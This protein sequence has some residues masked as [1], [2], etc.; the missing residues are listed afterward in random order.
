MVSGLLVVSDLIV[1]I[2]AFFLIIQYLNLIRP[3]LAFAPAFGPRWAGA[4]GYRPNGRA[5]EPVGQ[6]IRAFAK[7]NDQA[8]NKINQGNR[9][10]VSSPEN[11]ID[12]SE[13][14]MSS[15]P[16]QD[17]NQPLAL[18]NQLG[19]TLTASLHL[20]DTVA[21]CRTVLES[22][23]LRDLF[24]FDIAE[25]CLHHKDNGTLMAV[26]RL[27]EETA[28]IR[29]ESS[30][31]SGQ[32]ISGWMMSREQPLHLDDAHTHADPVLQAELQSHPY[33]AYLGVPLKV[34]LKLLGTFVLASTTPGIYTA[35]DMTLL[36]VV[37]GQLSIALDHVRLFDET[38][39][40]VSELSLLFETSQELS[41]T[42]SYSEILQNLSRQMMMAFPA[43][44]C[45]IFDLDEAT[46]VLT[47][48]HRCGS[49]VTRQKRAPLQLT[50][51]FARTLTT[52]TAWEKAFKTRAPFILRTN[53]PSTNV[54][55]TELL[56]HCNCQSLLAVPL[57]S[58]DKL[59]G[60]L[61]LFALD[62][63]AFT[64]NQIPLVQSLAN[65]AG[66]ALDN[67]RL[68]NLTDQRLQRRVEEL[69]GLQ[70]VSDEL[71]STLDLDK[72]LDLVL[73]EAMRVT[74]AD[75]GHVDLY[76]ADTRQLMVHREQANSGASNGKVTPDEISV[77]G[78]TIMTQALDTGE[79]QLIADVRGHEDYVGF[80]ADTRSRVVVPIF[81]GSEPAGVINLESARPNFFT[82]NQ[83]RYLESLANQAAVAIGN[84]QAYEEQRQERE[85]ASRRIDQLSRLAEISNIFRTNRPLPEVLE[86]IAYAISESVGYNIVLI[87]LVVDTPPV[88]HHEVGAGIGIPINEFK[89]FF[90]SSTNQPLADLE[91]I[92]NNQFRLSK[93]YFVPVER[94]EVWR[95]TFDLGYVAP[96]V[97]PEKGKKKG[98]AWQPGDVLFVPLVDTEENIIGLLTVENPDTGLRP[99]VSSVETLEIFA[100]HA[101]TAIENARLFNL[102][103][104]RRRLADTL[105]GVAETISSQLE[106]DELL[107][108]VLR[109]LSNV[110]EYDSAAVLRLEEDKLVVIGARAWE[111]SQQVIGLSYSML[112]ENPHRKVIETQEPVIISDAQQEYPDS[113]SSPPYDRV[114]SWLGVPLTYGANIL[115]VMSL[116]STHADFFTPEESDVTL[117]FANQVAVAMQNSRLFDEARE[118]VRQLAAL[119]EVAQALNRALDLN[120]VLNLVLDAVFD[121]VGLKQGSIWLVDNSS[122]TIKIANTQ[123]ISDF[124]VEMFNESAISVEAEPFAS[125]IQSGDVLVIEGSK[126]QDDDFASTSLPFQ[127]LPDDVTYV[128]LKTEQGV[129]G[130][131][132]IETVIH[133]SNTLQLIN[134]L[135]DLAAIAI[136]STRLL[137]YTRQRAN[138]MQNLYNLGVE[139][140]GMLDVQQVMRSVVD[141]AAILTHAQFGV[142]LFWDE[143]S[144]R[145]I[146][147]GCATN[148][149]LLAKLGFAEQPGD[150]DAVAHSDFSKEIL[151]LWHNFNQDICDSGQP[152]NVK[153]K[154]QVASTT[155]PTIEG[156][157]ESVA[158]LDK[159]GVR[160]VLGVPVR[161]QN[162]TNGA[163]MVGSTSPRS[164]D[165]HDVQVLSFVANQA[166][167]AVRN[168]QLVQRLNQFTEE[169]ERRVAQRTE[170]LAQTLEDLTVER[171]RVESLYQITRELSASLDVDRILTQAL[172]LINRA[173]GISQGS[174][175]LFSQE[176]DSLDYRA[177][178]GRDTPIPT[179]P[180]AKKEVDYLLAEQVVETQESYIITDLAEVE[181]LPV[182]ETL[183]RHSAIAVPLVTGDTVAG[184]LLLF[185]PDRDYFTEDHLKLVVAAASQVATAIN[186]AELY[187]LITDQA[188]RLGVMLRT[189]ATEA[190]KN[191]A[192]L[193]GITDGVLVLD[194]ERNIV[195][196]NPKAVEILEVEETPAENQ[197]L[198]QILGRS[199]SPVGRELTQQVYD[200]LLRAIEQIEEGRPSAE[201]RVDVEEKAVVV[202]LAPVALG[203]EGQPSIVTV[204]RDISREAEI[205]RIKNE[206]ISTVSHELRTP[207]TS[208]KGYADL[209]V[210]S[211]AAARLGELNPTQQ[212]FVEVIQSNANRLDHLVKDILEISRI[213]TDRIKL[214]L[215]SVNL[216]DV[217]NEVA[218]SFEGQS[219]QKPMNFSL[220]LPDSLPPV[221]ADKSRVVQVMVNLLSNAW[222]YTPEN[223]D[224]ILRASRR[225][226]AFVQID[227]QDSGIGIAEKDQANIFERFYR[228]EEQVEVEMVDGTGLGLSIT[229]SFVEML[230][231][232]IWLESELNVGTTFSF[233]LPVESAAIAAEEAGA[234]GGAA[235][236]LL[237]DDDPAV[238]NALK[239]GLKAADFGVMT[240]AKGSVG[241]EMARQAG[242]SLGL[243]VL[244]ALLPEAQPFELL[245]QFRT[246]DVAAGVP[247]LIGALALNASADTLKLEVMDYLLT[248]ATDAEMLATVQTILSIVQAPAETGESTRRILVAH[249]DATI[250]ERL[251]NILSEVCDCTVERAYNS[252]QALDMAASRPDLVFVDIGMVDANDEPVISQLHQDE[253]HHDEAHPDEVYPDE[254]HQDEVHQDEVY[255][256][257]EG[258]SVP[259]VAI[260]DHSRLPQDGET[261][262]LSLSNQPDLWPSFSPEVL[263]AE[264]RRIGHN[265][266]SET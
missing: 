107:N 104:Q 10:P 126:T 31:A 22:D 135:A 197:P 218:V 159:L 11:S 110:I 52:T 67:S 242:P 236:I 12:S 263:V 257:E 37:A 16:P 81:Y 133:S 80:G 137:E 115:G 234:A 17:L 122:K 198:Q 228:A 140:T 237:I 227:V 256:D 8:S 240:A 7:A 225:D 251:K 213:E 73:A 21:V 262:L 196:V 65:Q 203:A 75:L 266:K 49:S 63:R 230:G 123:N 147:D 157:P 76:D 235:K 247:V 162:K 180:E 109:E 35:Q 111:Y 181:W 96:Q 264:L 120:E 114:R 102:E 94:S 28:D 199:T 165:N 189:Q 127:A 88:V 72:I 238:V 18:V 44:D 105:R 112:E 211:S 132:A 40:R 222:R 77:A 200:N 15:P 91:A 241:L 14:D 146:L 245:R 45:A 212:R 121:L 24:N 99:T 248:S 118:Q 226:D 125:V 177:S 79:T 13:K 193:R 148:D 36:E 154:G 244:D 26:L 233:T 239:P 84:A 42:L 83:A 223:G 249:A 61:V 108:I 171:D 202:T 60:L 175:L 85:Q 48:V 252:R 201:F 129:I 188:D 64:E 128:P 116:G 164:F 3:D 53:G 2:F 38:Q 190:A 78:Q 253:A 232:E 124:L 50:E 93:S 57:V 174:I 98:R 134:T 144:E 100:N 89:Q 86:D 19:Q 43:D 54:I 20:L 51:S 58:R 68:F 168:A 30:A 69:S 229:K 153:V 209:L 172:S 56:A 55:E 33:R 119:T 182:W 29:Q 261:M 82:G 215:E 151:Q 205:E 92:L 70:R 25:I 141:N 217:I 150:S 260:V 158:R 220:D 167:V 210:S 160:A 32:G 155:I 170:E 186:N 145:Y 194:A 224:I 185:H 243:I 179:G 62:P 74:K 176:S 113:F 143:E 184:A 187:R 231:G 95:G 34:G 71:N 149:K 214:E 246:G 90:A 250:A 219:V 59:T 101:A 255:Q 4:G 195:L 265:I 41:S 87:S 23:Q 216:I 163:L 139:I 6:N 142:I 131:L 9:Q 47:L 39:H 258:K 156:D 191:E 173:V 27:P 117:A 254:V 97:S 259:V 66:I 136:D 178:L 103:Q 161:V 166:A 192:I 169:L 208:I 1:F 138:E 206:F 46:G 221:W 183:N 204:L 106:L 152:L 5:A 130:I 207:L